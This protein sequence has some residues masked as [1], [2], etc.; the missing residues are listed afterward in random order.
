LEILRFAQDD[1]LAMRGIAR[2]N[3]NRMTDRPPH[4]V[5]FISDDHSARDCGPYGASDVRTPNLDRLA[6]EGLTCDAAFTS[7]PTCAP[8]RSAMYT[9]LFPFRNGAHANHTL[10]KDN[11]RTLPH[12]MHALGYR[13]II[14][15]KTH[16]GPRENFPFEYHPKTNFMPPGKHHIL[17][18]DL[19][20]SA[21]D[22]II[23]SHDAKQ[24]LCLLVCAHSPHVYWE[25]GDYDPAKVQLPPNF[26][27]TPET[28]KMRAQYYNDVTHL[29][30]Q[31]GAVLESLARHNL[32]DD[33]LFLYTHDHGSQWPF[34]KWNLYDGGI[35]SPLIIRW[36]GKVKPN[37]RT[38]AMISTIDLL[39]TFIDAAGGS[40]PTDIDGVS[41][42]P[43]LN[44]TRT[45]HRDAI[46]ATH[47]GDAK[48]NRSPMRCVRTS[49]YKFIH[50]LLPQDSYRTHIDA[51]EDLD[52]LFYWKSWVER[53]KTDE[54]AKT[55][56]DRYHHRPAEEFF[57]LAND[58]FEMK[59]LANDPKQ[60]ETIA[61]LRDQ[62]NRWRL[63]QGEDLSK[64]P[65]PEDA[66]TGKLEYVPA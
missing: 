30:T 39:P 36:P 26:V 28:R 5:L 2:V 11:I 60:A 48:M 56:V 10:I 65:M 43:L 18:T 52:G 41:F 4:I 8:A 66:R 34:N 13:V 37:T 19:D 25:D 33:T 51:G 22:H 59:N 58:P 47:T 3:G 29:D 7:S 57:D 31:V 61:K 40:V 45:T 49:R 12:Y 24:P 35:H 42:L 38:D 54:K 55:L 14:A 20:T 62:L 32:A 16:I 46:Y 9:G 44:G 17:W 50:N 63:Q 15:G 21:I 23:A 1:G 64:I 6:S 53:A 27:D